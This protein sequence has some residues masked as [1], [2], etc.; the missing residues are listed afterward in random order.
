[1]FANR[2]FYFVHQYCIINGGQESKLHLVS[3]VLFGLVVICSSVDGKM[4]K[5][6]NLDHKAVCLQAQSFGFLFSM[7]RQLKLESSGGVYVISIPGPLLICPGLESLG[8]VGQES[9]IVNK[10]NVKAEQHKFKKLHFFSSIIMGKWRLQSRYVLKLW[11]DYIFEL[12][13]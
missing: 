7:W 3:R 1:M 5:L 6:S 13:L 10:Q 12:F 11:Q 4:W 9:L 8:V 2:E